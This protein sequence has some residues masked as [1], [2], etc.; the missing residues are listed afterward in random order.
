MNELSILSLKGLFVCVLGLGLMS[1]S[2]DSRAQF[3]CIKACATELDLCYDQ[4]WDLFQGC[5]KNAQ[6]QA[7]A[8]AE[9]GDPDPYKNYFA[10]C[11]S[12]YTKR[13]NGCIN[14]YNDCMRDCQTKYPGKI[15]FTPIPRFPPPPPV[16]HVSP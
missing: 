6:A 1:F 9:A 11:N 12:A 7:E 5:R 14:D 15:R 4:S 2:V 3:A 10:V 8:N 16:P 13:L